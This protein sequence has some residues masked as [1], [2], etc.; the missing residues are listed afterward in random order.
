[1]IHISVEPQLPLHHYFLLFRQPVPE[2]I[3]WTETWGSVPDSKKTP[4]PGFLRLARG[5]SVCLRQSVGL[6]PGSE[7]PASAEVRVKCRGTGD[8]FLHTSAE[9]G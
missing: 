9:A 6:D 1:M 5:G 3:T 4:R 8:W 2:N 7:R